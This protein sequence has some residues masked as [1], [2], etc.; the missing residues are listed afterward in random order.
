MAALTFM[1][2]ASDQEMRKKEPGIII[3]RNNTGTD[4]NRVLI[5][6]LKPDKDG[7]SRFGSISPVLNGSSQ[8]VVRPTLAPL[9]PPSIKMKCLHINGVE[10]VLLVSLEMALKKANGQFG[11]ALVLE[12]LPY[13]KVAVYI[14]LM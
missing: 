10:K 13:D 9:L 3:I 8:T 12:L 7:S 2:C 5:T 6:G 4:L 14:E 1:G 11:E